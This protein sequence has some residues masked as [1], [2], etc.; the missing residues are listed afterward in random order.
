MVANIGKKAVEILVE[1]MEKV[2]GVLVIK[3]KVKGIS[4]LVI[5]VMEL[6]KACPA[7]VVS[8]ILIV[9]PILIRI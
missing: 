9:I 2:S 1:E 5:R 6:V 4:G 7:G 8:M 3:E